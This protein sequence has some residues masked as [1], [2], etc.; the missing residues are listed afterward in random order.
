MF[1]KRLRNKYK[2]V[3]RTDI[4]NTSC[5]PLPN[6]HNIAVMKTE[7]KTLGIIGGGQLGRMTSLAAA[8]LGIKT[9]IYCPEENCPA[10][11]VAASHLCAGYND[12]KAL[13]AFAETV[14]VITYEFENI[15]L[16]T[17]R[18]LQK[19]KPVHPDERLLEV[20]QNRIMEKQFL[21]DIGIPTAKWAVAKKA[22]DIKM[23]T[24]E[25][26][27]SEFILKTTRFGYDGKGQVSYTEQNDIKETWNALKNKEII[28]EQKVDFSCEISIIIARD[29]L[30]QT[31]LYGPVLNQ[32]KNHILYKST[33]P[34]H[35]P[36]DTCEKAKTMARHLADAVDLVGVLALEMFVTHDNRIL[37]NEI[38]PRPHNSGHW[39]IDAC[40]V[41]QFEQ[42]VRTVCGMPVGLPGRHSDA[43][44]INLIGHDVR[45][46][47]KWLEM[48][49][50][51]VH[52]YGKD[53]I[54][55]G[56]KMGHVTILKSR[57][58]E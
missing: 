26:G 19:L 37:A 29:K 17:V 47:G 11:D 5:L 34:V 32:H 12:K 54:R 40:T 33:V 9:R 46:I 50:A 28:I 13:K 31:A 43:E 21:N 7:S 15:P 23:R 4:P 1:W 16:E 41:S 39:T 35:L 42:L 14:D 48:K 38:A 36:E 52:L 10:A 2:S 56:R 51:C 25:M 3:F 6:T 22:Q 53:E 8:R 58:L 30:G 55:E 27:G 57:D 44:M 45:S 20:S 18:Y 49:K 24:K